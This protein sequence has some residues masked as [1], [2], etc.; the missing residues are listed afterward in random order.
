VKRQMT[1]LRLA[2]NNGYKA[3]V[4]L[5]VEKG[6]KVNAVL[7]KEEEVCTL[8]QPR[9]S[10]VTK[11][12]ALHLAVKN[13]QEAIAEL[14]LKNCIDVDVAIQEKKFESTS[15]IRNGRTC[16]WRLRMGMRRW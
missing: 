3:M 6:A 11:Y 15:A 12:T 16:I 14:L 1:A 5:L 2:V 13:R 7:Q 4:Q 9:R 10:V 8:Y